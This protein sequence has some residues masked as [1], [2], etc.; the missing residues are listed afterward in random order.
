MH[1]LT[2]L[3]AA[4]APM[5]ELA[6]A[7]TRAYEGYVMPVS[8]S[9]EALA[10]HV[11]ANDITLDGS[12]LARDPDGA[13]VGVALLGG[14]GGRGWVGGVGVAP[15]WRGKGWGKALMRALLARARERDL[16]A[17]WLEVLEPNTVARRLYEH[18]GFRDAR[19]LDIFAGPLA[20][21]A[22]PSPPPEGDEIVPIPVRDA[23]ADYDAHH[24]APAPWQRDP[25]ALARLA[26]RLQA[27][28]LVRDGAPRSHLIYGEPGAGVLHDFGAR[29]EEDE[30]RRDDA[31]ALLCHLRAGRPEATIRAVNYPPG[32]PLDDAL[33]ALGCPVVMRQY[34]MA[35]DLG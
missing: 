24:R 2:L 27:I 28:A 8:M 34:E 25:A 4:D 15:E 30:R 19:M 11:R 9:A 32:D 20:Q 12:V 26:D 33:R 14:R 7:F 3:P 18:L 6:R 16:R 35:L 29:A 5:D 10:T 31:L 1:D 17:V 23:L 22:E 21:G 13:P